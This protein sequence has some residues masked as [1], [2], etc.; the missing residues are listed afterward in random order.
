VSSKCPNKIYSLFEST[1][2]TLRAPKTDLSKLLEIHGG[3]DV[4]VQSQQ[5]LGKAVERK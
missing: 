4:A 3:A 1:V 5:D 2:V